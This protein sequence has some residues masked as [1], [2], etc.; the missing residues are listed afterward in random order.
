[1]AIERWYYIDCDTVGRD[2]PGNIYFNPEILS[3][4]VSTALNEAASVSDHEKYAVLITNNAQAR[5]EHRHR[6]LPLA[7]HGLSAFLRP[8]P[9]ETGT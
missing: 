9:A 8:R 5:S 2:S 4:K 7:N 1:M 6:L 3:T